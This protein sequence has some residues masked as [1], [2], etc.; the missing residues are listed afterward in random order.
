MTKITPSLKNA[1]ERICSERG[2]ATWLSKKSGISAQNISKYRNGKSASMDYMLWLQLKKIL[3][4]KLT[5]KELE[6]IEKETEADESDYK[7]NILYRSR[8]QPLGW[9]DIIN[10]SKI[11]NPSVRD[12]II[13]KLDDFSESDLLKVLAFVCELN[14]KAS[15]RKR[16]RNRTNNEGMSLRQPDSRI[17]LDFKVINT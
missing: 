8:N 14:E 10:D 15:S 2:G 9:N 5:A 12:C 3:S 11:K 13:G 7:K 4:M 6:N 1:I 17:N 16:T